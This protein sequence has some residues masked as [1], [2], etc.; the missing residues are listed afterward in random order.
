[1]RLT[2]CYC[3]V[4]V[5]YSGVV[6]AAAPAAPTFQELMD[7]ARF[8]QVQRGMAVEAVQEDSTGV[9]IRTTGA[10]IQ[11]ILK[12]AIS[13]S[14]SVSA[15]NAPAVLH[16]ADPGRLKSPPRPGLAWMSFERPKI[17]LRVNGDSL[18]MLHARNRFPYPWKA[19]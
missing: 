2:A 19:R 8:P 7:P 1:M 12:Q 3:L 9:L 6:L 15:M 14:I 13:G 18:C 4:I 11:F 5:F 17:R 16:S 10:E